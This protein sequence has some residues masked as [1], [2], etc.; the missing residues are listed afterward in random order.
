MPNWKELLNE[1]Q[2]AGSTHDIV[3]R[4]YLRKLGRLSGRNVIAYYSGFQ[5]KPQ[6]GEHAP[7]LLALNDQD[8]NGFMAT[9]HDLDRKKGLDLILHTPGGGIAAT[10]AIVHYLRKMFGSDIRAIVP[11]VAM[12]AGTMLALSCR[13]IVLGKHS[14]LGPIDPQLGGVPAHGVIAEFQRARTEI[15]ADPRMG[16]VWAPLLAKFPPVFVY[17]CEQ[18]IAWSTTL[19]RQWLETGMFDGQPDAPG[20]AAH[21]VSQLGDP[22]VQH[23]HDR[24]VPRDA[25]AALKV[26]VTEL[27]AEQGFQDAVL[28]VHHAF[29]QTLT[30]TPACKLIENQKGVAFIQTLF[31]A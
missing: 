23:V 30:M 31:P 18:A 2:A 17:R 3:R 4:K 16:A 29:I 8:V 21:V 20:L 19:V 27:E 28:T 12:S 9:I 25:L 6:V 14:S 24:H 7:E 11:Q 22:A 26:N 15:L 10:E 1:I 5:Q 13:E